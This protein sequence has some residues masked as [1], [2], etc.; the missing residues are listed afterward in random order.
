MIKKAST[1]KR[2]VWMV[3]VFILLFSACSPQIP[4]EESAKQTVEPVT[5]TPAPQMTSTP[6]C[7]TNKI[8][9]NDL[10]NGQEINVNTYRWSGEDQL[11]YFQTEDA[12][13]AYSVLTGEI[14]QLTNAEIAVTPTQAALETALRPFLPEEDASMKDWSG[15]SSISPSATKLIYWKKPEK[16]PIP[17]NTPD[18]DPIAVEDFGAI[19][20]EEQEI[21]ILQDGMSEPLYL[22]K[23]NGLIRRVFWLP[24]EEQV[25]LEMAAFSPNYLLILDLS[26]KTVTSLLSKEEANGAPKFSVVAVSPDGEWVVYQTT[27]SDHIFMINTKTTLVTPLETVRRSMGAWWLP[28]KKKILLISLADKDGFSAILYDMETKETAALLS[29]LEFGFSDLLSISDTQALL[30]YKTSYPTSDF[31]LLKLCFDR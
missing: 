14:R 24:G 4:N 26:S 5:K 21:Y 6:G 28:D 13:W 1:Q 25:I 17:T 18:P 10:V 15:F 31:Y 29:D 20:F 23:V 2:M 9:L 19:A 11:L 3:L 22:G 27:K 16:A 8:K 12:W 7:E 30:T